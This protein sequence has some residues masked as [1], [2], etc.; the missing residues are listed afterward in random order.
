MFKVVVVADDY[1]CITTDT[2]VTDGITEG[3]T[4]T[5]YNDTTDEV[6]SYWR[7]HNGKW[8]KLQEVAE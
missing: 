7:F 3:S 5:V 2:K 8:R 4:L 1:Q 6:D